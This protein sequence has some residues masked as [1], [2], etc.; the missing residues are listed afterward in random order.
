MRLDSR[1]YRF[2]AICF[3]LLAATVWFSANWYHRAFPEASIDFRVTRGQA[4]DIARGFL[5]QLGD[6]TSGYREAARFDY[7][8]QAKTFLERELGLEQANRVM[9]SGVRL[10][11]WS[12]RWFK[13]RQ[14]E[15]F[16][17]DVTPRG[18]P[19][20]FAHLIPEVA[21]R[22]S[23]ST[24]QARAAAEAFLASRMGRDTAALEFVE[25]SSV[26]RPARADHVF[27][28]KQRGFDIH[29]ATYRFQVT[30]LGNEIGGDRGDL[31]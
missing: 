5:A 13:P 26:A 18:E 30:V 20:G 9:G 25:G 27:T 6:S 8:D 28:W 7:D 31:K 16:R 2:I 11:R 12:W 10:W 24:A 3:V 14:K 21:A 22:P 29:G 15:E 17:V 19:V 4:G 1:D 23:L